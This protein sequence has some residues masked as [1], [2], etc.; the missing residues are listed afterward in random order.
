MARLAASF[1]SAIPDG[2]YTATGFVDH[3]GVDAE[4]VTYDVS[5][6]VS[7]SDVTIDYSAAGD[8]NPGRMNTLFRLVSPSHVSR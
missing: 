5:V 1:I 3:N 8:A 6:V 4:Q 7:G 2:H